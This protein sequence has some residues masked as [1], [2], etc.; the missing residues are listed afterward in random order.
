MIAELG[1]QSGKLIDHVIVGLFNWT[2]CSCCCS[3]CFPDTR[4]SELQFTAGRK[5]G[6]TQ[7][8]LAQELFSLSC[9]IHVSDQ[10]VSPTEREFESRI[11]EWKGVCVHQSLSCCTCM[12]RGFPFAIEAAIDL[13]DALIL[14]EGVNGR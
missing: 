11:K 12:R 8:R 6:W 5:T 13:C 9:L 7:E 4:P 1:C 2:A 14:V 10:F 3:D